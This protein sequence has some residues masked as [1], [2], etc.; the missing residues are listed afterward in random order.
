MGAITTEESTTPPILLTS[1][2][3]GSISVFQPWFWIGRVA[4][5]WGQLRYNRTE[6]EA[7]RGLHAPRSSRGGPGNARH[8]VLFWIQTRFIANGFQKGVRQSYHA[9]LLGTDTDRRINKDYLKRIK[10][11]RARASPV[12]KVVYLLFICERWLLK[13]DRLTDYLQAV[14]FEDSLD[15]NQDDPLKKCFEYARQA[16]IYAD[17]IQGQ[18]LRFVNKAPESHW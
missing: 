12:Y 2:P 8:S 15:V 1:L 18:F 10:L 14:V 11:F 13:F 17:T 4:L 16:R 5:A 7:Q 9:S 3:L 6:R